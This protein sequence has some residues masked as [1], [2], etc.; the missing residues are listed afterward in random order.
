MRKSEPIYVYRL[1][2]K[3]TR[4]YAFGGK[5]VAFFDIEWNE[6]EEVANRERLETWL[7][8]KDCIRPG[9]KYLVL[10]DRPDFTFTFTGR[11]S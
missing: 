3:L 1:P 4:A 8:A 11:L 7:Q 10:S 6:P 2:E 5:P 9:G